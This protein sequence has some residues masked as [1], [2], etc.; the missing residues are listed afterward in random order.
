MPESLVD[1]ST[2]TASVIVPEGTD[3]RNAASVRAPFKALADRTKHLLDVVNADKILTTNTRSLRKSWS[4]MVVETPSQWTWSTDMGRYIIANKSGAVN[5]PRNVIPVELPHGSQLQFVNFEVKQG[6]ARATQ[7]NRIGARLWQRIT[8]AGAAPTV[9]AGPAY[10][11]NA[12][13]DSSLQ[14]LGLICLTDILSSREY[15]LEFIAG[16]DSNLDE[17]YGYELAFTDPGPRNF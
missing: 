15:F 2:Y 5:R 7:T 13:N 10:L 12:Q 3:P 1:V 8:G 14:L 16:N 4:K 6:V 17:F 9:V 11:E